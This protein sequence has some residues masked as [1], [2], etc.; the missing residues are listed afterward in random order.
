M[1]LTSVQKSK[2]RKER[3]FSLPEKHRLTIFCDDDFNMFVTET[4][5]RKGATGLRRL[6]TTA[7]RRQEDNTHRLN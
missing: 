3:S 1:H 6:E 2:T 5:A 7:V 4:A